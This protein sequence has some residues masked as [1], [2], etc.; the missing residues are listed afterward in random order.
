MS[1]MVKKT[2]IFRGSRDAKVGSGRTIGAL[3][4]LGFKFPRHF[5]IATLA[6]RSALKH[7]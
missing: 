6:R 2:T 3:K 7:Q 4:M 5:N 1:L